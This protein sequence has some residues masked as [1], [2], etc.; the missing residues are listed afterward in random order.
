M[1]DQKTYI[2]IIEL[3]E[4][5]IKLR[6]DDIVHVLYKENVEIDI[7]LQLRMLD[8][9]NEICKGR[10]LPFL[11]DAREHVTVTKE[12]RLH[13]IEMEDLTPVAA[14]AVMA[15]SLAYKLIADF[16]VKINKPKNPFK[17]FRNEDD[18]I[19]WLRLFL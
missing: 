14:T 16:Y 18:A 7:P 19:S 5:F 2:Q 3:P 9:F 11:F 8:A 15:K 10:K 13:A 12:A 17:V 1:P 4:A 6:Q